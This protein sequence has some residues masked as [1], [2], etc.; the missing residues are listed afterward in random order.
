LP[1]LSHRQL[2]AAFYG[3]AKLPAKRR[4]HISTRSVRHV[5]GLVNVALNKAF[6]L[7]LIAM[8]PMLRV[9]LPTVQKKDARSLTPEE[10]RALPDPCRGDWTFA[11]IQ[12]ALAFGARRGELLALQWPDVDCVSRILCISKSLEQTKSGTR[13]KRPKNGKTRQCRLPQS[14]IAALQ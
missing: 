3:L 5:A 11:F 14:A 10:I 4:E 7:D 1:D 2:E 6:R 13:I 8:N 12:L 9:E